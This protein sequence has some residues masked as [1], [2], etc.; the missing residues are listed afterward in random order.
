[1]NKIGFN[2]FAKHV[3]VLRLEGSKA[4]DLKP[5][6]RDSGLTPKSRLLLQPVTGSPLV[7]V[8]YRRCEFHSVSPCGSSLV[9]KQPH[10]TNIQGKIP[11]S[12]SELDMDRVAHH[13]QVD[14]ENVYVLGQLNLGE[15]SWHYVR[16]KLHNLHTMKDLV[17]YIF[18]YKKL[19]AK[20]G[21]LLHFHALDMLALSSGVINRIPPNGTDAYQRL[22]SFGFQQLNQD[23]S[24]SRTPISVNAKD[25]STAVVDNAV[26]ELRKSTSNSDFGVCGVRPT[27]LF[28][29]AHLVFSTVFASD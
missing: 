6:L 2:D 27:P 28:R 13:L 16:R 1:M 3:K 24:G 15:E 22:Q 18:E 5:L 19:N 11:A 8:R 9:W 14:A 17:K 26:E 25:F 12:L 10:L 21:D 20:L 23:G 4:A 7:L 29:P